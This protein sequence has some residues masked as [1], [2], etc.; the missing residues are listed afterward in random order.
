M[1]LPV[2]ASDRLVLVPA[3]EAHLPFLHRLNG[4]AE[5]MRHVSGTSG[6]PA[7]TEA[8][9]ARRL[10]QR[11]DAARGLGYWIGHADGEPV[12]WWGLGVDRADPIAGELGFRLGRDR[13]RHGLGAEG[14]TALVQHGFAT[15]GL[16]RVWAGTVTQNLASRSTLSRVGLTCTAEPVPGVLTYAIARAEW[17]ARG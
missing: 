9:W 7:E 2:L 11:S 5:V 13:W 12:G 16:A 8:E 17:L 4:D 1:P 10:G 3:S 6:S 14:A 15:V